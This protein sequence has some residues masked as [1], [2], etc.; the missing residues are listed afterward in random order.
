MALRH[1][2]DATRAPREAGVSLETC[3]SEENKENQSWTLF[4]LGSMVS[5]GASTPKEL[6]VKDKEINQQQKTYIYIY[7]D[8]NV[9]YI[10]IYISHVRIMSHWCRL[11]ASVG[12]R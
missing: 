11:D 9:E 1:L 5:T 6:V 8:S 4:R 3:K 7:D 2:V 10:Y 12:S